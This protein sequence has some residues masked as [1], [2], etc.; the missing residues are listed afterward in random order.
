ME[1]NADLHA[2]SE[3]QHTALHRAVLKGHD[4]VALELARRGADVT[5]S[6]FSGRSPLA[7]ATPE[8]RAALEELSPSSSAGDA[9]AAMS[10]EEATTRLFASLA[11]G[12][13]EAEAVRQLT[14]NG[15][16]FTA[17]DE[18]GASVLI[19]AAIAGQLAAV[20][21]LLDNGADISAVDP[22]LQ[23]ALHWA[24]IEGQEEVCKLLSKSPPLRCLSFFSLVSLS[25]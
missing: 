9:S 18:Y 4:E 1:S 25:M 23:T 7:M 24:A 22:N 15:I 2:E 12:P 14:E 5:L 19:V 20:E 10:P 21:V 6:D 8:L 17:V 16:D 11:E 13:M 3:L